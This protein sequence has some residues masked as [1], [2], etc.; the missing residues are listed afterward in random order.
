MYTLITGA[1]SGIGYEF[2]RQF[3]LKGHNLILASRN[4]QK[5]EEIKKLF[6]EQF[7][8]EVVYFQIDLSQTGSAEKVF[9]FCQT[10]NYEVAILVNNSGIG[11][12]ARLHVDRNLTDI[13]N[14]IT[15]NLTT[16]TEL[17]NLFGKPMKER[18]QGYI[19]NIA[20][21]AAFQPMPFSAIYGASK[22]YVL[23]LS[24]AM[25]I[26]M[27]P[28]KVGIT[29]VCP[30]L[31]N[32]NFFKFEKPSVPGWLYKMVSPQLVV[33][34]SIDAMYRKKIYVIPDFQ[35]WL[36]AQL[37]RFMPRSFMAALMYII[38]KARKRTGVHI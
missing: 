8:I 7:K 3:A 16:L 24:E 25:A 20:S 29:V 30:G 17:C 27:K 31:T 35:H 18:R 15:L 23:M 11:L 19:V 14:L 9:N 1:T 5:M 13:N 34:K 32:T 21:T 4:I 10:N 36:L 6:E 26:E 28:Y 38:E 22:S 2:A 37:W 12:E 33:K